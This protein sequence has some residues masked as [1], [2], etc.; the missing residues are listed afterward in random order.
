MICFPP[1]QANLTLLPSSCSGNVDESSFYIR[2]DELN[3]TSI[4][5]I[6]TFKP[7]NHLSFDRRVK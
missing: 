4:S 2:P 1:G 5:D 3:A 6:Q 7:S